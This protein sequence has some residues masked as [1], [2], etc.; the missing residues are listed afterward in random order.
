YPNSLLRG[1]KRCF[2][3]LESGFGNRDRRDGPAFV[4]SPLFASLPRWDPSAEDDLI[5]G[6]FCP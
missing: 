1:T 5:R 3:V 2:L 4:A 6:E